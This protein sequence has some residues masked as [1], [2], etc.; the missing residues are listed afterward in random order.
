MSCPLFLLLGTNAILNFARSTEL[1]GWKEQH[2]PLRD[3]IA[4]M[5][6]LEAWSL[7]LGGDL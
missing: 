2:P 7:G 3:T 6:K 4:E 1:L 5:V